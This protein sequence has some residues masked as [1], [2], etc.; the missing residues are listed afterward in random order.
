M[1]R[2]LVLSNYMKL[3]LVSIYYKIRN[4]QPLMRIFRSMFIMQLIWPTILED[5]WKI[6]ERNNE[7]FYKTIYEKKGQNWFL[8]SIRNVCFQYFLII[9]CAVPYTILF[10]WKTAIL[11]GKVKINTRMLQ[12]GSLLNLF[13]A[14]RKYTRRK[15]NT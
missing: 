3:V 6:K 4:N 2:I 1:R 12:S 14:F 9:S 13:L 7:E 11:T 5:I 10:A 15:K 8:I